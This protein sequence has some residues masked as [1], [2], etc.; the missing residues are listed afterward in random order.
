M[1]TEFIDFIYFL[2]GIMIKRNGKKI[3]SLAIAASIVF[4][5]ASPIMA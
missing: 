5:N 2:E 4:Q 3:A 1:V